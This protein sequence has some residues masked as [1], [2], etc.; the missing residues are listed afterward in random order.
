MSNSGQVTKT[1]TVDRKCANNGGGEM[2]VNPKVLRPE[3]VTAVVDTREQRPL[4][5]TPLQIVQDTLETGDYA[6]RGLEHVAR[7]ERKSLEDLVACVGRDRER[8][9][10]E[11]QR[12]LAFPVRVLVVEST[13]AE[14]EN[15]GWRG[16]I[17]PEQV[18]GS[19]LGWQAQGLSIHLAGTHERAG[20]HVARLLFTIARRRY[21]EWS[22]LV[23]ATSC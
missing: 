1:K 19:L 16:K 21:R 10:R 11:V 2:E 4:E 18:I 15:G 13:W 6:I 3:W 23:E 14:I 8:F 12:L 7:I 20:R 22:T 5:L 17:V 9:D